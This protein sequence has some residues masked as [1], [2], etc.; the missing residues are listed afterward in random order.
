MMKPAITSTTNRARG[1]TARY[2]YYVS[3]DDDASQTEAGDMDQTMA[4]H[5]ELIDLDGDGSPEPIDLTGDDFALRYESP[6][7][8]VNIAAHDSL[9]S[10]RTQ[11]DAVIE[12]GDCVECT[13]GERDAFL[14]IV[15]ITQKHG[16]IYLHGDLLQRTGDVDERFP[17]AGGPFTL[18]ALMPRTK[19]ELCALLQVPSAARISLGTTL[20]TKHISEAGVVRS[21]IFTNK[22]HK[23]LNGQT[24]G[25]FFLKHEWKQK[26]DEG[27]LFCRRKYI[28]E[29]DARKKQVVSFQIRWIDESECSPGHGISLEQIFT[30]FYQPPNVLHATPASKESAKRKREVIDISSDEDTTSEPKPNAQIA[31]RKKKTLRKSIETVTLVNDT[32]TKETF[33]FQMNEKPTKSGRVD[34]KYIS[35]DLCA[36]AGGTSTGAKMA[37]LEIKYLLDF[38]SDACKTLRLNFPGATVLE[39]DIGAFSVD[40]TTDATGGDHVDVMH[41]SFPCQGHSAANTGINVELDHERIATAYGALENILKKCKPRCL[42][43][44]QVPGILWKKDGQHFRAQ[45]CALA[46]AGYSLRWKVVNF[47]QHGNSQAR[48]RVIVIAAW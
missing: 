35:A 26:Q 27:T 25:E 5:I 2:S 22:H 4:S 19:N 29:T 45:V 14:R 1:S 43:L 38:D 24:L 46:E 7:L 3:D 36:G 34:K 39:M 31:S 12:P 44:E 17:K 41:I 23:E 20:V 28:E 9:S 48:K 15:K 30:D 13:H 18:H 32:G 40:D 16:E 33:T 42:T 37:G 6:H 11:L 8:P 47:A 10:A 21:V